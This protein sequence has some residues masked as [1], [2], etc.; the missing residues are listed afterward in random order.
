MKPGLE[1]DCTIVSGQRQLVH[2]VAIPPHQPPGHIQTTLTAFN[3]AG[4]LTEKNTVAFF[5]CTSCDIC[6][7]IRTRA[8]E[9]SPRKD[10]RRVI[11]QNADLI[12][13][14]R[15]SSDIP[16]EEYVSVFSK[17]AGLRQ[18]RYAGVTEDNLRVEMQEIRNSSSV[19]MVREYREPDGNRL[20]SFRSHHRLDDGFEALRIV[21][22][23]DFLDRAPGHMMS[24]DLIDMARDQGLP[25]V[26]WGYTTRVQTALS[27]KQRLR[28]ADILTNEGWVDFKAGETPVKKPDRLYA[29]FLRKFE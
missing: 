14:D 10:H 20:V 9:F 8:L 24:L 17:Y 13:I 23:P 26:Y 19:S 1:T 6:V 27:D 2:K 18:D 12:R 7:P 5:G 22:D 3:R 11:R 15:P 21:Y 16:V 29:D 25:Y 28:P 4:W